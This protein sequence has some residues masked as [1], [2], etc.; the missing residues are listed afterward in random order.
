M[1]YFLISK[2]KNFT[3][4]PDII[5]WYEDISLINEKNLV[6]IKNREVFNI[7]PNKNRVWTDVISIPN[8]FVSKKVKD[9]IEKYDKKIKFK[10]VILLDKEN[11]DAEVY[12]LPLLDFIE[13][14]S[15]ESVVIRNTIKKGVLKKEAIKDKVIFR[16]GDVNKRYIVVRLDLIESILRRDTRGIRLE[17]IEVI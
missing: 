5:N 3:T 15:N 9:I 12:Y 6:K 4:A 17:E 7:K 16:I 14:L 13:C 2:D 10:Q 1:K 11:V 8:F